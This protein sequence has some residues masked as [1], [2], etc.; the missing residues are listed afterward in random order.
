MLTDLADIKGKD[1]RTV[2]GPTSATV[3]FLCCLVMLASLVLSP[4]TQAG[5]TARVSVNSLGQ[6]G[7][8]RSYS[9]GNSISYDGHLVAIVSEANNLVPGDANRSRDVFVHDLT[10]GQTTRVSVD[11][12]GNEGNGDSYTASISAD[13]QLV[14]FGSDASNLVPDDTNGSQ[15]AFIHDRYNGLTTRVSVSS[16][17]KEGNGRSYGA[18]ISKDNVFVAFT[19]EASNLVPGDSNG[20]QD[21][22][23]HNRA[24][25]KT[26]RVSVDSSGAAGNADSYAA[27]ISA[28]G[29]FVVFLSM[30]TNLVPGDSNGTWD[31]FVHDRNTRQTTRV[32]VHS[33]GSEGNDDSLWAGTSADG[34]LVAFTSFASNLVPGDTNGSLDIFLH[35]RATGQT[36]R[37]SI[38]SGGSEGNGDSWSSLPGMISPNGRFVAFQSGAT[39]LVP[40][41]NNGTD[42]IFVHDLATRQTSRASV[43]AATGSEGNGD[44]VFGAINEDGLF[45]VFTSTASNLVSGDTNGTW[46]VFVHERSP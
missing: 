8:E 34:Q 5:K 39:N 11:S 41:D 35:D 43:G 6:Q 40:G 46:D 31:V 20:A 10:S 18:R 1:Y 14:G 24:S 36:K 25:G 29:R 22:F 33:N 28:N 30:A 21:V 15:D 3:P 26:T 23:V 27:S 17:G 44:S 19:S 12:N 16:N 37:V 4:A 7:K 2:V 45:V 13:G 9:H 38:D 42:D 32:S